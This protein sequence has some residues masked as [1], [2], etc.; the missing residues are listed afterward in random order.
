MIEIFCKDSLIKTFDKA[1]FLL[2]AVYGHV[3]LVM[4]RHGVGKGVKAG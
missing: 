1:F 3:A 4:P 2:C